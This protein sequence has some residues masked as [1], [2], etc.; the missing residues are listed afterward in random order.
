MRRS[1]DGGFELDDD[2][3]RIDVAAVHAYLSGDSYWAKGRSLDAVER[4]IGE[5][6][7][8]VGLYHGERQ[9][10]FAR[11]VDLGE[12][13]GWAAC[14]YLADVYVLEEFRG[15]GLGKELVRESVERGPYASRRWLLRTEDAHT[16]YEQFGFTRPDGTWMIRNAG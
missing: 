8:V 5:A 12:A 14:A 15:R 7:R 10:G 13:A 4:S 1:L 16:L 6:A 2:P 11:T 3:A 9:I